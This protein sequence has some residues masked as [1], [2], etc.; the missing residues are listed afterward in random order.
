MVIR[1]AKKAPLTPQQI[2]RQ[3]QRQL[4]KDLKA[5][6]PILPTKITSRAKSVPAENK[7]LVDQIQ[8]IKKATYGDRPTWNAKRSRLAIVRDDKTGKARSLSE[9]RTILGTAQGTRRD[10]RGSA[11]HTVPVTAD[12][13]SPDDYYSEDYDVED[14]DTGYDVYDLDELY[15]DEDIPNDIESAFHYH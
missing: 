3:A 5:G 13:D 10:I 9:L 4:A 2:R 15:V 14:I 7:K 1:S 6:K 12:L 11:G 8:A